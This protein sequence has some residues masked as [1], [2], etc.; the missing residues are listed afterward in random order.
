MSALPP[1]NS[2]WARPPNHKDVRA[3][4]RYNK[5][6]RALSRAGEIAVHV[7]LALVLLVVGGMLYVGNF[8]NIIF[9]DG[10]SVACMLDGSTG[11]IVDVK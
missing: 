1:P 10:T 11:E 6:L 2:T 5:L 7:L 9:T 8:E 4:R 3:L